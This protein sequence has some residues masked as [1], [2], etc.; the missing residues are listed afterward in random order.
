MK[1][2]LFLI[3]SLLL[4]SC[5]TVK[6]S[7]EGFELSF[8]CNIDK[9]I[10][11][12]SITETDIKSIDWD[13]QR[14]YLNEEV[15]ILFGDRI[16]ELNLDLCFGG[17][18]LKAKINGQLLYKIPFSC[19]GSPNNRGVNGE[20]SIFISL[21]KNRIEKFFKKDYLQLLP[22]WK[23]GYENQD[24]SEV[25]RNIKLRDYFIK[26]NKV[27]AGARSAEEE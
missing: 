26:K 3:I 12:K 22:S 13:K 18:F 6:T 24:L 27:T 8:D 20:P 25:L 7:E 11:S 5:N 9:K 10:F 1:V 21:E 16:D 4:Y 2:N 15:E 19:N 17:C 14:I 23:E